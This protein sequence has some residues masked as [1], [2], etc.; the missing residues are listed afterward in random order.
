MPGSPVFC[1][2]NIIGMNG[3]FPSIKT[4]T[5]T[6]LKNTQ[7]SHDFICKFAPCGKAFISSRNDP[8]HSLTGGEGSS[9]A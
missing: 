8:G 1:G 4:Y 7:L 2:H 6:Y 3:F 9:R 5:M